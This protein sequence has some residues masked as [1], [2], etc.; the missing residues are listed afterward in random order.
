MFAKSKLF[1]SILVVFAVVSAACAGAGANEQR[2][3]CR[4]ELT[5]EPL[6]W[7]TLYK[8]PK[9]HETLRN[10]FFEFLFGIRLDDYAAKSRAVP[11]GDS[12]TAYT[13]ITNKKQDWTLSGLSINDTSSM[14]GMTL[15]QLYG[16][17][18]SDIGYVLYNDQA[19]KVSIVKEHTKGVVLF[20]SIS[21]VWIVHSIPNYPP[22]RSTGAYS[23]HPSQC[24]FGQSMLC[25]SFNVDQ[26]PLV[27]Q[28]LVYNYPQ[29]YDFAI[30]DTLRASPL[31]DNIAKATQ[32]FHV[33]SKVFSFS[34][35]YHLIHATFTFDRSPRFV[36]AQIHRCTVVQCEHVD[37]RG[38]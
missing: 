18:A 9:E 26:L 37:H 7:F 24:I 29:I 22:K 3:T 36:W 2:L 35:W 17:N 38:R 16:G 31:V 20:N 32:A 10:N 25:M 21:A 15:S 1:A 19:D 4:D 6:D 14:P 11:F 33:P 13:Y 28:Q 30:P 23:I 34:F 12:G 8:L 5:G 27:G